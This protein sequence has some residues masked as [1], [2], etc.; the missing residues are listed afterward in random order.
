MVQAADRILRAQNYQPVGNVVQQVI[1]ARGLVSFPVMTQPGQCYTVFAVGDVGVNDVDLEVVSPSGQ[2]VGEDRATDAHPNVSFCASEY[3]THF[4]RVHMFS[5][6]GNVFFAV[7]QG[8]AGTSGNVAAAFTGSTTTATTASAPGQPDPNTMAR[9]Q[10]VRAR[11]QAQGYQQVRDLSGVVMTQGQTQNWPTLL[12]GGWCYAFATFGGPGVQDSDVF[13][14]D[15]SGARQIAGDA[16]TAVDA[17]IEDI[18]TTTAASYQ[19]RPRLYS[20]NGTVWLLAM[21]RPNPATNAVA[22]T[23]PSQSSVLINTQATGGGG[24][25]DD[26]YR[27]LE[28]TLVSLGYATVGTPVDGSLQTGAN[29]SHQ[30]T[31]QQGNCYAIA[32]TGDSS[33]GDIDLYL[34]DGSGREIDRDYAMDAR[35]VVRV[36]P[37]TTGTYTVQ[38]NMAAGSGGYRMGLFQ[39]EGGTRGA[40]MSGLLFVRNAEVTRLLQADGYQGDASFELF[41]GRVREGASTT[42]TVNL[43]NGTCYAFVAVGGEGVSDLNMT[44]QHGN[45]TVAEDRSLTAFPAVRYCARSSGQH[46]VVIESRHGTGEFVFRVFRRGA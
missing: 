23:Q 7:Y 14:F 21:A 45:Q 16:G 22:S 31:L 25:L 11:L 33:V 42:R 46:R 12:P 38:V 41:R 2:T 35:P 1:P 13:L 4:A 40:G 39:W 36:C 32:A 28:R 26:S 5:G 9:I 20:G 34:L 18:C 27:R 30:V 43:Q 15:A 3:G 19:L 44:V 8:P 17:V 10:A 6:A 29:A 24:S 37:R